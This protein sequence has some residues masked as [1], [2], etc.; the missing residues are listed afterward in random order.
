MVKFFY[1]L[2]RILKKRLSLILIQ[3]ISV[4][5]KVTF[6]DITVLLKIV[7]SLKWGKLHIGVWLRQLPLSSTFFV[8]IDLFEVA[9]AFVL[10]GNA[11]IKIMLSI[12]DVKWLKLILSLECFKI[13]VI[14]FGEIYRALK[15]VVPMVQWV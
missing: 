5:L 10:Y 15:H 11:A 4:W 8:S 13:M 2:K 9:I 1:L 14:L 7:G 3:K 6:K 12:I